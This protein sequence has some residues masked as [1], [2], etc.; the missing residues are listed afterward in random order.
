MRDPKRIDE[1][2][3]ELAEYWKKYPD[4]RFFQMIATIPWEHMTQDSFF[5]ED[6][7]AL[8]SL[9]KVNKKAN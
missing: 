8:E 2:T 7:K 4:L 6:D 9:K 1:F 5:Y 3:K